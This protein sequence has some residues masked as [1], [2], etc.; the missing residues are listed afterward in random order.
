MIILKSAMINGWRLPNQGYDLSVFIVRNHLKSRRVGRNEHQGSVMLSAMVNIFGNKFPGI[1]VL[2][3]KMIHGLQQAKDMVCMGKGH[4]DGTGE[5]LLIR[6]MFLF[7]YPNIQMPVGGMYANIEWLWK[8]ILDAILP[9]VK[10]FTIPMAIDS[11]IALKTFQL[12][13]QGITPDY[14]TKRRDIL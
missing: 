3:Q 6:G 11:I 7:G 8:S 14:I 9:T 13:P 2:Q 12:C 10:L 1:R 4:R 5:G